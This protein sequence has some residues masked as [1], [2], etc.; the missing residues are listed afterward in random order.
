MPPNDSEDFGISTEIISRW[1]FS[2]CA[3]NDDE[4]IAL[5]YSLLAI[6]YFEF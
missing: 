2:R 6:L 3:Q 4:Y 1:R 5:R